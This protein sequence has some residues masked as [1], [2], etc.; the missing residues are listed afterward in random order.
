MLAKRDERV[1]VHLTLSY[2]QGF[3]QDHRDELI[4]HAWCAR[5]DG[6]LLEVTWDI[7]NV[8]GGEN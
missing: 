8:T 2:V 1:M 7:L 5:P 4:P 6:T 3:V